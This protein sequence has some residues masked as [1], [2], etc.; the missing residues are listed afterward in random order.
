[1]DRGLSQ[2]NHSVNPFRVTC[3]IGSRVL[4]WKLQLFHLLTPPSRLGKYYG[5]MIAVSVLGHRLG[6]LRLHG[7]NVHRIESTKVSQVLGTTYAVD[8]QL[9]ESTTTAPINYLSGVG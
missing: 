8:A 9:A 3:T 4:D 6:Q 2:T 5:F 1:M 7:R